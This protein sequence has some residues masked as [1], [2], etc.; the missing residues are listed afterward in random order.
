MNIYV[1]I[2]LTSLCVMAVVVCAEMSLNG[3]LNEWL[4][5]WLP[6]WI[7]DPLSAIL[8]VLALLGFVMLFY[9][10]CKDVTVEHPDTECRCSTKKCN[11]GSERTLPYTE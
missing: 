4:R 7:P 5:G 10:L 8:I 2:G 1:I 6:R 9:G 11:L 3:K